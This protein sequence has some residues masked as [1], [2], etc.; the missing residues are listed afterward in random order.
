MLIHGTV[1]INLWM[2][3]L[4]SVSQELRELW[5]G[6]R[7]VSL[8][9]I[10]L[11][12]GVMIGT[13]MIYPILL[14][15][16]RSAF[17]LTLAVSGLLLTVLWFGSAIGQLPGGI[18]A[19]RYSERAVM[20]VSPLLVALSLVVVI[21]A[22]EQLILFVATGLVGLGQSLYPV[23]RITILSHIYPDRLGSALG[24]T[25]ATG[26]LGQ[27]VLPPIAGVLAVWFTWQMGFGFMLPLLLVVA[28]AIWVVVPHGESE[29]GPAD[30]FSTAT[31]RQVLDAISRKGIVYIAF[32][33]F[34]Y[35]FT[36]QSFAGLYPTYL[37]EVKGISSTMAGV[38]FSLFFAT[39][40]LVKPLAGVAYDR[41]G[42]R[43]SLVMLLVGP[44]TGLVLLPSLDEL[45][46]LI[47][48]TVLVSTILGSGTI[49]QSYLADSFAA[50]IRGTGLGLIRTI[51]ATLG[52][53]GPVLFGVIA[54][55][56]FFDE[57]Y[58]GLAIVIVVVILLTLRAP[59]SNTL[60]TD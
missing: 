18:L 42:I 50:E 56:G 3:I 4:M 27:T 53:L 13:R 54:G 2:E 29:S 51:S 19:D 34:L 41:I 48:A 28:I 8:V 43:Y 6:G 9:V 24:V 7:G 46:Q 57:G 17:D 23:A 14:P 1:I 37:V 26:D 45:W 49:T 20:T 35:L 33:L 22:P 38:L 58:V 40:V 36:W 10:A 47:I 59:W 15:Y 12:W 39:G 44:F 25:M 52:A 31:F 16:L 55:R 5:K 11:G 32:I 21:V 60:H 30:T